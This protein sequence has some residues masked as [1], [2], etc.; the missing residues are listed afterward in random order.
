MAK[1]TVAVLTADIKALADY[2]ITDTDLDDLILKTINHALKRMKR[3]FL[4]AGM[5]DEIGAHDSFSTTANQE[6]VDIATETIDFD[7]AVVLS[8][9]TNDNY[10]QIIPFKEYRERYPDPTAQTAGTP[11]T[12]AFFANRLYLGPTPSAVI[13]LY[14]DYVKLITKLTSAGNLPY[15]DEYDELVTAICMEHLTRWLDMGNS[16]AIDLADRRTQLLKHDLITGAAKQIGMN[17]QVHSRR[18]EVP[19]FSPRRPT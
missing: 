8:E 14:L 19:Y 9:R 13:T 2:N 12:A 15:E 7:E 11:D 6:Y 3:W 10:I 4:D 17:Q 5:Y 16:T 1:T 18:Q